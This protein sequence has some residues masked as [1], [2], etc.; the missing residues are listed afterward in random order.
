MLHLRAVVLSAIRQFFAR[1]EYLEVETPLLS[2]DVV[3]DAHL[4]PFVVPVSDDQQDQCFLQT[5][6]E[7]GMKR[8]LAAGSGSIFQITRSFR[9]GER[10]CRHNPE[11]TIIEWYGV[12]DTWHDQM[13]FTERLIHSALRAA[14]RWF[15]ENPNSDLSRSETCAVMEQP[16]RQVSYNAAFQR[17]TGRTV[18]DA[19]VVE[20]TE[21]LAT[22]GLVHDADHCPADRDE[23]L[24]LLL[25]DCVEPALGTRQPEFLT[26]Y[27]ISQAALAE[28][29]PVDDRTACRFE[30]YVKGVELCN[31]YQELT[32][33]EELVR[34]DADGNHG[35]RSRA[36]Q[37]L[38]G[39]G[40][41]LDAMKSGLPP[42]S[43]VAL[44]FDRLIMCMAGAAEIDQV[45]P[46]PFGR[47]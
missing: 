36:A 15:A 43:G 33:P 7:A 40:H 3:V 30:L 28:R 46:F 9:R 18:L 10:G 12:G 38:P 39:A 25:A 44:G 26:D 1:E 27:P 8:L 17:T 42:C 31:G 45:L 20:L 23:L 41:L 47:H 34:R 4:D 16:F 24:N 29:N 19:S 37:S 32:D 22:C 5:S 21:L 2:R 35:R 11:F 14:T 13:Q 6:P